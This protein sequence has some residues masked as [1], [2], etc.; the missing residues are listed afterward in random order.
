MCMSVCACRCVPVLMC[1]CIS[2]KGCTE[3]LSWE[4]PVSDPCL[5]NCVERTLQCVCMSVCLQD[6]KR[7][8]EG[9]WARS[10]TQR[11]EEHCAALSLL[12]STPNVLSTCCCSCSTARGEV[13]N[14][15]DLCT[16]HW[17]W[18]TQGKVAALLYLSGLGQVQHTLPTTQGETAHLLYTWSFF[19][20]NIQWWGALPN[21]FI[22]IKKKIKN[23]AQIWEIQF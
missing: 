9:E 16:L 22:S 17:H 11:T 6:R 2:E 1:V 10:T 19:S 5:S 4:H 18:L 3:V 20:F 23:S 7:E 21:T 12:R 13:L 15:T 14:H 8:T